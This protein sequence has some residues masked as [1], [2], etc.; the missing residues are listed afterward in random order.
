MRV[1]TVHEPRK[2]TGDIVRDAERY[3]FVRDG[4]HVWAFL[5]GPL[6]MIWWRMW[7]VL[8]GYVVVVVAMQVALAMLGVSGPVRFFVGVLLALL[9]GFEAAT[10]RRFT[11]RKRRQVGI[12]VGRDLEDAERR[13]FDSW[14]GRHLLASSSPLPF[15]EPEP[16]AVRTAPS[17]VIGLFPEPEPRR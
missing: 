17:D 5:L 3:Q 6:W 2:I 8:L 1:F 12:V 4:F 10:L 9:V 11:L 13:F 15:D 7:L 14:T 16:A